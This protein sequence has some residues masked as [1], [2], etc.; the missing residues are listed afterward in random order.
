M[1]KYVAAVALAVSAMPASAATVLDFDAAR[2]P[3]GRTGY[4]Y[5]PWL[6]DGYSVSASRCSNQNTCFVTTGTTLSSLD[7]TGAALTNM[8]GSATTTIARTDG[9]AFLLNAI[10][11]ANN[12]GNYSGYGPTTMTVDF[13]F[14]FADGLTQATTYTLDNF[15]GQR[16]TVNNLTFDLAPLSSF[17]FTPRA[18]SSGFVQFDNVRLS[19]VAAVP[20]PATWGLM[21]LG[22]GAVGGALRRRRGV[23]AVA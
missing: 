9:A 20:E 5:G 21:I 14:T 22:F 12:Y 7:R 23:A 6:E 4:V 3:G 16:L 2:G 18:G 1:F 19:D 15:A 17:S 10:D 13:L 11:M 8:M